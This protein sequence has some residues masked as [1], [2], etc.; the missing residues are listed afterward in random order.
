MLFEW[1]DEKERLNIAKHGISFSTAAK[2]FNDV[3]RIEMYDEIHSTEEDRYITI[4][5]ISDTI[6]IV[7][8]VYTDRN[9]VIRIISARMATKKEEEAYFRY[10]END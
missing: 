8:L 6:L 9:N 4:G 5:R 10:E 3:Y 7:T 1:D 2:L